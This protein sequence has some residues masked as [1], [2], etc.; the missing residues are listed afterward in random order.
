MP[1]RWRKTASARRKSAQAVFRHAR[2][3]LARFAKRTVEG[4]R[5]RRARWFSQVGD[6]DH[7]GVADRAEDVNIV[8]AGG[9]GIHS[10][11]VPTAFSRRPVTRAVVLP[12]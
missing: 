8:V 7:I 4:L 11:F 9:A 3:P 10:L 6:P 2:I 5:H 1:Q 12:K